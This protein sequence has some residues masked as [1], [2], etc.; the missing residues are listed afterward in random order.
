MERRLAC[1]LQMREAEAAGGILRVQDGDECVFPGA[2]C[3]MPIKEPNQ[4]G[5]DHE[6]KKSPREPARV[7]SNHLRRW[8]RRAAHFLTNGSDPDSAIAQLIAPVSNALD[9]R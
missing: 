1:G 4:Y 3:V 8:Y 2:V 6:R 9:F 5:G 7:G